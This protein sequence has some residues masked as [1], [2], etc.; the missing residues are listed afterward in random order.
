MGD[1]ETTRSDMRDILW[2]NA[3][4]LQSEANYRKKVW[5]YMSRVFYG[6]KSTEYNFEHFKQKQLPSEIESKNNNNTANSTKP[7]TL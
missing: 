2:Q 5:R 4:L 6:N 3:Q 1:I 7:P